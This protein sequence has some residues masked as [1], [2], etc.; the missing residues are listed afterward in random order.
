MFVK[1]AHPAQKQAVF[2]FQPQTHNNYVIHA[3]IIV[4]IITDQCENEQGTGLQIAF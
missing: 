2:L 4:Q 1:A 3:E